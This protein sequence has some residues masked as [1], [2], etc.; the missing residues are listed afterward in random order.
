MAL[1]IAPLRGVPRRCYSN[2]TMSITVIGIDPGVTG[3]LSL[4]ID[5]R[6]RD[7]ADMPIN[8]VVSKRSGS[9]VRDLIG[10]KKAKVRRSVN[11]RALAQLIR[12][13]C[14]GPTEICIFKERMG[15][16]PRQ[17]SS[18]LM[19]TEG[20][21]LGVIGAL[22]LALEEPDPNTW[23]LAM[24]L[25]DDK[26]I[27]LARAIERYPEWKHMFTRKGDHD[28]AEAVFLGQYGVDSIARL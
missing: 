21:L 19:K 18:S 11:P 12:G 7:I 14:T 20:I 6:L 5:G 17:N 8:E 22:G 28:R 2:R 27:S 15:P 10:G 26:E 3:A 4:F 13:W 1:T 9:A 24:G 25:S 16:R 23:K